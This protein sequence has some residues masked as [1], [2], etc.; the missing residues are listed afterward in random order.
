MSDLK[1]IKKRIK[2]VQDTSKITNAMYLIA[3]SKLNSN[4]NK[5]YNAL[6]HFNSFDNHIKSVI[7]YTEEFDIY[8]SEDSRYDSCIIIGPDKGFCG[9]LSKEL[10]KKYTDLILE[11]KS[12]NVIVFGNQ[13]IKKFDSM[14][15]SYNRSL[16]GESVLPTVE[17]A[18]RIFNLID[19]MLNAKT[20]K[21]FCIIYTEF[22]NKRPQKVLSEQLLPILCEQTNYND[23]NLIPDKNEVYRNLV[24]RYTVASI[25]KI[26]YSS[27][28]AE[29]SSRMLA[30]DSA[31]K[32]ATELLES[33]K[34]Q[35]NISRQNAITQEIIEIS[36]NS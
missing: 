28:C 16:S 19:N 34:K 14:C 31:N 7:N 6:K 9:D 36:S 11:F 32:N 24:K 12:D 3:T 8:L 21:G 4:R 5:Y 20:S 15:L 29:Q 35:Y 33:L 25:L 30:M 13:L 1:E 2:S 18:L 10:L 26:L 27:Y 22:S 17:N 23:I